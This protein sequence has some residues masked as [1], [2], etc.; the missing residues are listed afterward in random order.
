MSDNEDSPDVSSC[1][2]D[3]ITC[4]L[5]ATSNNSV[6]YSSRHENVESE[7]KSD[8]D[9]VT[10][11]RDYDLPNYD[12]SVRMSREMKNKTNQN[13]G[14]QNSD[15]SE[16]SIE[17]VTVDENTTHSHTITVP[18]CESSEPVF[19]ES[20]GNNDIPLQCLECLRSELNYRQNA[21]EQL[22]ECEPKKSSICAPL[23]KHI[24]CR[25]AILTVFFVV[26]SFLCFIN[27]Y[28]FIFIFVS[29]VVVIFV[30]LG[31]QDEQFEE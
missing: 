26:L 13:T 14:G 2:E 15:I 25:M 9:V 28:L 8:S 20:V 1:K 21:T 6:T 24:F 16:Q 11:R 23:F 22:E 7:P 17:I 29:I 10:E 4:E 27:I 3:S 18:P 19:D 5:P 31:A 12:E 30:N